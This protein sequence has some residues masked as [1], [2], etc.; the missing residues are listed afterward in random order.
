M[1]QGTLETVDI[2][3]ESFDVIFLSDLVQHIIRP[4]HFWK[5]LT[6]LLKNK[7][8]FYI[9]TPDP[10]HWSCYMAGNSWI[11]FKEEHL[12]FYPQNAIKWVCTR[13]GLTLVDFSHIK[14]YT[15]LC[16]IAAQAKQFG[17]K[18]LDKGFSSLNNLLYKKWT[19]CLFP[20]PL[21]EARFVLLKADRD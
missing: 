17:P 11:H 8:I 20:L 13:Y 5:E 16:Y 14:K 12:I 1:L 2:E 9:T 10:E 6:K 4:A 7:G 18:S 19:E 3:A 21:G 15:N